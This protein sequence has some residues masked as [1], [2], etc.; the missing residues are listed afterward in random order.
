M[1]KTVLIAD[2]NSV[3]I[4]FTPVGQIEYLRAG[5]LVWIVIDRCEI[6][7]QH[8]QINRKCSPIPHRVDSTLPENL[9][10]IFFA[11]G[12]G[13][14]LQNLLVKVQQF[15]VRIV[16]VKG[17]NLIS[18]VLNDHVEASFL[19]LFHLVEDL[20]EFDSLPVQVDPLIHSR[21]IQHEGRQAQLFCAHVVD[22]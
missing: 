8:V 12:I 3:V 16:L 7:L 21:R 11:L 5:P 9:Q 1:I 14:M 6:A 4:V 19:C 22:C 2:N 10:H 20:L 18:G 13:A 17:T 15:R